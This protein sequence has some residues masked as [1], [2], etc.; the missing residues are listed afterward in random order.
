[1]TDELHIH[2]FQQ[3]D[4]TP[5]KRG[6][7]VWAWAVVGVVAV[8]VVAVIV[9]FVA[10]GIATGRGG[11]GSVSATLNDGN[12]SLDRKSTRLNSS[13]VKISYAVFCLKKKTKALSVSPR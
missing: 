12:P 13:H 11:A 10:P 1:M 3:A 6:L 4:A 2:E 5:P 9:L 8:A 7:P